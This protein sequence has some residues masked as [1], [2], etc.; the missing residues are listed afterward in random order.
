MIAS[1]FSLF[2]ALGLTLLLVIGCGSGGGGNDAESLLSAAS[3]AMASEDYDTA[4]EKIDA[5]LAAMGADDAAR[6]DVEVDRVECMIRTGDAEKGHQAFVDLAKAAADKL[7]WKA[8]KR[9]AEALVD[10]SYDVIAID[11][12]HAAEQ[13]F[14]DQKDSFLAVIEAIKAKPTSGDTEEKLRKLGYVQ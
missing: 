9:I 11:V 1:R 6:T 7:D 2:S 8:H 5:A 12:L 13:S 3:D 10:E 4:L 14:P